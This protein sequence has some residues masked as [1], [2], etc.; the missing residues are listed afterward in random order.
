MQFLYPSFLWAL[1][2]LAIP[3]IIHLFHFRRFKKAYFTNVKFL[4]EIKEE[5]SNRNRLRNLLVLLSRLLALALLVFA[6]AQ[7]IIHHGENVKAGRKSVSIFID[8]SFSMNATQNNA[9][10]L[11]IAKERARQIVDAYGEADEYQI[12]TNELSG[13]QLNFFDQ[14]TALS[15]ID[16]IL[17]T[18]K[19][20]E[21][22]LI[23]N[24]Q[25]RALSQ[26]NT[27]KISYIIS[28]F[29]ESISDFKNPLDSTIEF[30][31][32]QIRPVIEKNISIDE[33]YFEAVAPVLNESNKLLIKLTNHSTESAENVQLNIVYQGQTRPLGS[34]SIPPKTSV[35]DTA[36]LTIL[37][38]GWH[39]AKVVI[40]DYPVTFDDSY[41]IAFHIKPIVNILC[42]YSNT[43]N[44]F[45]RAAFES[46]KYFNFNAVQKDRVR[47]DALSSYDLI[48]LQDLNTI[49][50]GLTSVVTDFVN[51]GGNVIIFPGA[52]MDPL[53]YN[54]F[55]NGLQ[56]NIFGM[57]EKTEKKVG[58]INEYSFVF[59]NVF[60]KISRNIRLP[61]T[62]ANYSVQV[63]QSRAAENIL[64]YRDGSPYMMRYEFGKGFYIRLQCTFAQKT[65]MI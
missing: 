13:K 3:I 40:D 43:P 7:P 24:V 5:T 19:V 35:I 27:Q 34:V 65:T 63:S 16:E 57:F 15:H 14:S 54:K 59:S 42:I 38:T 62:T 17:P 31:L 1:L 32:L 37:S 39:N 23:R 11:T 20:S 28:D 22:P 53:V 18:P 30:N 9:T 6:F 55:M 45:L 33:C 8:N 58:T 47:Y 56:A 4:K 51:N 41:H 2:A 21:L 12:I 48:I 29:Q 10:I 60:R 50:S 49:S 52:Q 61:S 44:S 46:L 26:K 36:S 64:T 25:S